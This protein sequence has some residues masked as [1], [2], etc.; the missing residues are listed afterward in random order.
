MG[1]SLARPQLPQW[2]S[3]TPGA[4]A[5]AAWGFHG[6]SCGKSGASQVS[7]PAGHMSEDRL[8]LPTLR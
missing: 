1:G 2:L 5:A 8:D 4:A 6:S 7:R 3:V